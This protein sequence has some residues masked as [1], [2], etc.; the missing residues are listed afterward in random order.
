MPYAPQAIGWNCIRSAAIQEAI[1]YALRAAGQGDLLLVFADALTRSWKQ[2]LHF[3]PEEGGA[4]AKLS[5]SH[6]PELSGQGGH[7]GNGGQLS[8][9]QSA[10]PAM[11]AMTATPTGGF[12]DDLLIRDERGVRLARDADD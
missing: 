3:A 4:V 12:D 11:P 7:S 9:N 2:I 5:M 1:D 10:M 8:A 6:A